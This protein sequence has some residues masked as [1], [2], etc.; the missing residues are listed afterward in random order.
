M[1]GPGTC[2][3]SGAGEV[4]GGSSD[5]CCHR[6]A[7]PRRCS[8][9]DG[10]PDRKQLDLDRVW[11]SPLIKLKR[12]DQPGVE[13]AS[14]ATRRL[15]MKA[16]RSSAR[17]PATQDPAPRR[18]PPC[19]PPSP[20]PKEPGR[21]PRCTQP[22][23]RPMTPTFSVASSRTLT[24]SM[25]CCSSLELSREMTDWPVAG[26]TQSSAPA[27]S[28]RPSVYSL[29]SERLSGENSTSEA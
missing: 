16:S 23:P 21:W 7:A 11:P 17:P 6:A 13:S 22:G 18:R 15:P 3:L 27:G 26:G 12:C 1:W 25:S 29:S 24:S 2:H 5:P 9:A 8:Q 28:L 14:A 4:P 19:P 20:A 10:P